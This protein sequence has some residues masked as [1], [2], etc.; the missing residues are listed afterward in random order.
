[1]FIWELIFFFLTI[2]YH[3]FYHI[4]IRVEIMW[5]ARQDNMAVSDTILHD[6]FIGTCSSRMNKISRTNRGTLLKYIRMT[7]LYVYM[8]AINYDK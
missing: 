2:A 6:R 8:N 1:M 7:F 3:E 5:E 4:T